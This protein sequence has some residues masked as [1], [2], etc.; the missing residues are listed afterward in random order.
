MCHTDLTN[1]QYLDTATH[2]L[3]GESFNA[4]SGKSTK[5][6]HS[7]MEA[8]QYAM[9]G[10]G[11][12]I[13]LGRFK[14]LWRSSRWL[15]S[16]RITHQFADTYVDRAIEYRKS[17][18]CGNKGNLK[19]KDD[20]KRN[21]LLYAMAAQTDDRSALRNEILQTLMA[22]QETTAVLIS[23]VFFLLSRHPSVCEHLRQ[24]ILCLNI[25]DLDIDLLLGMKYL[26]N[27]LNEG[28]ICD[29]SHCDG[30]I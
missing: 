16:C 10:S 6:A 9:F 17:L 30:N 26:R 27:V 14:F 2:F 15:E 29:T 5:D 25:G 8:F 21:I 1:T 3:F 22:A 11:F 7:F 19:E 18:G 4:V 24:E 20:P 12:R 28:K 13:A 23:N